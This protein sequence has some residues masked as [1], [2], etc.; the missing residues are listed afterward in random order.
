MT[1]LSLLDTHYFDISTKVADLV[2]TLNVAST[3]V[4]FCKFQQIFVNIFC[5]MSLFCAQ[6]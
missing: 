4:N 2:H 1:L 6:Q 5:A 3:P